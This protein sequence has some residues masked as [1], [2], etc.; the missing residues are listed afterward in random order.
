MEMRSPGICFEQAHT[1]ERCTYRNSYSLDTL[2]HDVRPKAVSGSRSVVSAVS[3]AVSLRDTA[4]AIACK[5]NAV[6][7][8]TVRACQQDLLI[9]AYTYPGDNC[10]RRRRRVQPRY[11]YHRFLVR[12]PQEPALNS[13]AAKQKRHLIATPQQLAV[14]NGSQP[15]NFCLP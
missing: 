9:T 7:S 11:C 5:G 8:G 3:S 2:V 6:P 14:R 12:R 13:V 15:S 1:E 4:C 10:R